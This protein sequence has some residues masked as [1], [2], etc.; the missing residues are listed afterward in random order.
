MT[1]TDAR[2]RGRRRLLLIAVI[3]FTPML[4]AWLVY[5]GPQ[6]LR[7]EGRTNY[8]ELQQPVAPLELALR[9]AQGAP[10]AE[11]WDGKWTLLQVLPADCDAACAARVVEMRQLRKSLHRRRTRV[12]RL[13]V[14]PDAATAQELAAQWGA[15]QPFLRYAVLPASDHAA[16]AA[17]I[18]QGDAGAVALIDPLGN[19]VLRYAGEADLRGMYKDIKRLLKLS[20]IG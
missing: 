9:D 19:Y 13:V 12:Q 17:R 7:P 15:E 11:P 6:D 20:N 14:L 10:L 8:G 4:L 2:R 16:L 5:F 18:N 1:D 3:F